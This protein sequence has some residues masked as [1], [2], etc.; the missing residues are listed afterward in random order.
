MHSTVEAAFN[1]NYKR[2]KTEKYMVPLSTAVALEIYSN[3]KPYNLKIADLQKGLILLYNGKERVGEGTGFGFPVLIYPKEALFSGSSTVFVVKTTDSIKIRKEFYMD[4]K[5]RNKLGNVYL[6]NQ[7][8]R[9][10]IR[11]L[12]D[13][14]Q[15]NRRFR[16][17][18]LKGFFVRMGVEATFVKTA[19]IGK[20]AVIYEI[21]NGFVN[22]KVD[23]HDL[24]KLR[25]QKVF[26]LNEQSATF[27]RRYSDS[28]NVSLV[29][30]QIGAWDV[31]RSEWACLTSLQGQVGYRLWKVNG[32]VLLRGCLWIICRLRC[33]I[34]FLVPRC[35]SVL[36]GTVVW[37]LRI[38]RSLRVGVLLGISCCMRRV[39]VKLS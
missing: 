32:S 9:A 28:C 21:S 35:L 37:P 5:A 20:V 16:Y 10:F 25:P 23:F 1:K 18:S 33:H 19:A 24:R 2:L 26:V 27:F 6:E 36:R 22:A 8:V 12:T 15:K 38:G 30:K 7:K 4:R 11:Y 3:T 13:F 14:Y 31:V 17:L 34:L 29:D 39:L